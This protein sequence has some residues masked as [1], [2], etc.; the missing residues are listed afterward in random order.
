MEEE[1]KPLVQEDTTPKKETKLSGF[2]KLKKDVYDRLCTALILNS[3]TTQNPF[4][5]P[6]VKNV[7]DSETPIYM[8]MEGMIVTD[9]GVNIHF[10]PVYANVNN[11]NYFIGSSIYYDALPKECRTDMVL[12][13]DFEEKSENVTYSEYGEKWF[14]HYEYGTRI[15]EYDKLG[16]AKLESYLRLI[17]LNSKTLIQLI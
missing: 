16:N 1:K 2:F 9:D 12:E 13:Q 14:L 6:L 17:N 10:F 11:S 7:G 4:D 15:I 3:T 5:H 8:I